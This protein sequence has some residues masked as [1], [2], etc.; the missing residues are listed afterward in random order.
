MHRLQLFEFS[1]FRW[2]P[3]QIRKLE[4]EF[5]AFLSQTFALYQPAAVVLKDALQISGC[6]RILDLCSGSAGPA[7]AIQQELES[8][9][10][11]P[12][13]LVLSDKYPQLDSWS[14][15]C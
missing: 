1:D 5:L 13:S 6:H 7:V 15:F 12:V 8:R 2:F 9:Y 14:R 4:T 3:T 11:Y 10:G